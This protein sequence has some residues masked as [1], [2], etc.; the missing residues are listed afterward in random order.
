MQQEFVW[1]GWNTEGTSDKIWGYFL[2]NVNQQEKW[3]S[4]D[5]NHPCVV[6]WAARSKA[7][8]LHFK[9]DVTGN[10]LHKLRDSKV[11]KG[12]QRITA[13]KLIEL[14]P[15]FEQ[16]FSESLLYQKLAGKIR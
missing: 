5:W 8:T 6:F 4:K 9:S 16:E 1:I 2:T 7:G 3:Q 10:N 11:K 14:W 13:E 12:Y 15:N